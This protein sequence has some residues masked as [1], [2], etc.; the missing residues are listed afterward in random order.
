MLHEGLGLHLALTVLQGLLVACIHFVRSILLMGI[1]VRIGSIALIVSMLAI[2][3]YLSNLTSELA[4][5][6]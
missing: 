2:D 3:R 1:S 6:P 5:P 4:L